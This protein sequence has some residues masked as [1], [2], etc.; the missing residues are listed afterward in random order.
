MRARLRTSLGHIGL[1]FALLAGVLVIAFGTGYR[2][3]TALL[4]DGSA[5][6]VKGH[7]AAHVNGTDGRVDA[8]IADAETAKALA[9]GKER[10]QIV[11]TPAGGVYIVNKT[12]GHVTPIDTTTMQPAGAGH[13]GTS[14]K[15]ELLAGGGRAHIADRG[16]GT[17]TPV[18]PKTIQPMGAPI[19]IDGGIRAAVADSSGAVW[20]L[21]DDGTTVRR[22]AGGTIAATVPVLPAGNRDRRAALT[23]V[24]NRPVVVTGRSEVLLIGADR[25]D[26]TLRA[27]IP[28][29]AQVVL[30]DPSVPG[31]RV[32]ISLP[33][34]G[35]LAWVDL[36][37]GTGGITSLR[38]GGGETPGAAVV[39][40]GRVYV[41]ARAQGVVVVLDAPEQG[42]VTFRETIT[43][44]GNASDFDLFA[45]DDQVW[46][47]PPFDQRA[48]VV[49]P[50][51]TH[52]T[53]D[54]GSGDGVRGDH[55]EQLP[56]ADGGDRREPTAKPPALPPPAVTPRPSATAQPPS[57]DHGPETPRPP[58]S[59]PPTPRPTQQPT[60]QPST[61]VAEMTVV[62][63]V[64]GQ[65]KDDACRA[66][67][68]SQ[69]N[70]RLAVVTAPS[71][72]LGEV[73]ASDPPAG[74]RV[75]M[76]TLVTLTYLGDVSVPSLVGRPVAE[77]C[78]A[79]QATARLQCV[80]VDR[81]SAAGTGQPP[82]VVVAQ[83]P[84]AGAIVR[85]G[86]QVRIEFYGSGGSLTVP[87][88]VGKDKDQACAD[89][90]AAGFACQQVVADAPSPLNRVHTQTPAANT[91]AAP[92]T[93]VQVAYDD[94]ATAPLVR[95]K[96]KSTNVWILSSNP[97]HVQYLLGGGSGYE[98]I[99]ETT[100]GQAYHPSTPSSSFLVPFYSFFT[101]DGHL[102]TNRYYS[103]DPT[104]PPG[105]TRESGGAYDGVAGLVFNQQYAGTVPVYRLVKASG[106]DY[107][108]ATSPGDISYY[109]SRG[110][111]TDAV[112]GYVWP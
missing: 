42:A 78:Q 15:V 36:D 97:D 31:D 56:G 51:G 74:S 94:T 40:G 80:Q 35:Q 52:K 64:V 93:T 102:G 106:P 9:T 110:F 89:L 75:R 47:N 17:I 30:N 32:W 44:P 109:Q 48:V 98:Y 39:A 58:V 95:L 72:R 66:L 7:T 112:L 49:R 70:C 43:V 19:V 63:A 21:S 83:D 24:G 27:P 6:L 87:G 34:S 11:Q 84:G 53:I 13:Q 37:S 61:G 62:P 8:K 14:G 20:V 22:V 60:P 33:E 28:A 82:G 54:K 41:P 86:S 73:V 99:N 76:G 3:S 79:L 69:L 85:F 111:A 105:W 65:L 55:G 107:T 50:D 29:G 68:A 38:A 59:A 1:V 96:R 23:L 26:Q 71:G 88:V 46:I 92:G 12:T 104:P 90:A 57:G 101:N 77:A 25:V 5:W 108:Y 103:T 45:K 67:G 100:L 4:S 10:L 81:G 91:V 18:N 2:A 16:R